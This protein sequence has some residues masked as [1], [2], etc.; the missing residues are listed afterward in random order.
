MG[1]VKVN[2]FDLLDT[3]K[4]NIERGNV[5]N[6][7][8]VS[9]LLVFLYAVTKVLSQI[10][11]PLFACPSCRGVR[12]PFLRL[13]TQWHPFFELISY[14]AIVYSF[15][16]MFTDNWFPYCTVTLYYFCLFSESYA[17]INQSINKKVRQTYSFFIHNPQTV[18]TLWNKVSQAFSYHV[19]L[20][21]FDKW[22]C[23]PTAFQQI[24]MY[25][26]RILTDEHVPLKLHTTKYFLMIF[27]RHI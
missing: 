14:F 9:S 21:H 18:D 16:Q 10:L 13:W 23:T 6:Q 22:A 7:F 15:T 8:L 25:P 5:W 20:Q 24:R 17:T 3:V 19:P 11:G 1:R 12:V 27:H 2:L 26:F 4:T